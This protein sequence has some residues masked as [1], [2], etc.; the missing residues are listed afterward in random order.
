MR[1][2][3]R[4]GSVKDYQGQ[5]TEGKQLAETEVEAGEVGAGLASAVAGTEE[6]QD[7]DARVY[8]EFLSG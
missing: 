6:L 2:E 5:D 7:P 1:L 3:L 8:G 4:R